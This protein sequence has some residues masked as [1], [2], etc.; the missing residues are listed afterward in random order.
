MVHIIE[1]P[2]RHSGMITSSHGMDICSS[3]E[4]VGKI[5]RWGRGGGIQIEV[6]GV[7]YLRGLK[8]KK[9]AKQRCPRNPKTQ[10][11]DEGKDSQQRILRRG[12]P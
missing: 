1:V 5:N 10:G 2:V 11:M 12:N 9:R 7:N 4:I 6:S 8:H 3:K